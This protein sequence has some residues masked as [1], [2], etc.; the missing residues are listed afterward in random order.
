MA[1]TGI[2]SEDRLV[3]ATF[4]EHLET[5]LGWDNVYAWNHETFGPDGTL[6]RKDT[7]E[8]VLS[9]DMRATLHRLNSDCPGPAIKDAIRAL[10]V[11]GRNTRAI[12]PYGSADEAQAALR[13]SYRASDASG[14]GAVH[15]G[16][17][18]R[19]SE[20]AERLR[21]CGSRDARLP[22]P[23]HGVPNPSG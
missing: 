2:N 22:L 16:V 14:N 20:R 12:P 6:G 15:S 3:Q 13:D 19:C 7:T 9:R 21:H 18:Q 5:V 23:A 11:W 8:A 17:R 10:R 4:A 1:V